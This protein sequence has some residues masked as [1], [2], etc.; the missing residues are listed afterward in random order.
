MTELEEKEFNRKFDS[1]L[2]SEYDKYCESEFDKYCQTLEQEKPK[3]LTQD[4]FQN[5]PEW[6]RSAAVNEDGSADYLSIPVAW[7]VPSEI[8]GKGVWVVDCSLPPKDEFWDWKWQTIG[9]GYDTTNWQQSAID[10]E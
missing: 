6:V 8:M 10:N 1:W 7:A 9:K 5:A 3:Q 2:D 4:V